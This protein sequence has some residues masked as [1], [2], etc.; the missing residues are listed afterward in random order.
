MSGPADS[1]A[2][3]QMATAIPVNQTPS[4]FLR[5]HPIGISTGYLS[6]LRSH[7]HEQIDEARRVSPFAVEVSAL[8]E[9]ELASLLDFFSEGP[10]LPFRYLSVHGPSKERELPEEEL[11]DELLR[12]PDAVSAIVMHPDTIKDLEA[13]AP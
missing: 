2:N 5:H 8:S 4:P 7:W 13:Y 10:L 9:P 11:V 12:L 6:D 1:V 3:S